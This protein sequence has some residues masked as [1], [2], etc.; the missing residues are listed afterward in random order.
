MVKAGN[1]KAENYRKRLSDK[2]SLFFCAN[3]REGWG[4]E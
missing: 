3:G 4:N 1:N 2:D